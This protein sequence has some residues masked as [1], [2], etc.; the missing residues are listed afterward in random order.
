MLEPFA[1]DFFV[2][3]F[4]VA[5]LVGAL[6]GLMGVYVVLR[7]MS[8][9]GHGLSHAMLGG[10]V[11]SYVMS[12]N[13]YLGAGL[14]GFLSALLIN[15]TVQRRRILGADAV[16]GV[17]TTA[18]FAVGV[19][20]ISRY[21]T[22]TRNFEAALLGEVLGIQPQDLLAVAV[23]T[24]LALVFVLLCY[25][26]LLFMTFDPEVAAYYGVQVHWLD[27][28]FAL[29]LAGTIVVSM[30]V[31]GVTMLVAALVIPAATARLLTDSFHR[32]VVLSV[33]IGAVAGMAG[34]YISYYLDISSGANVVLVTTAAFAL[35]YAWSALRHRLAAIQ[36]LRALD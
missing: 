21:R 1:Y 16:I 20:L 4:I 11:V 18:S 2:R 30:Q 10:A 6:C 33:A 29:A 31:I 5:G 3:G 12:F 17:I 13:F 7:R 27:A 36:G 22:F 28:L 32:L 25:R 9:I 19:A 26:R 35:A 15:A 14:W 23:M 34:M 24:G 8:Y